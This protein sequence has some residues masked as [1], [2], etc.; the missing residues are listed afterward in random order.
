MYCILPN[1]SSSFS[2]V[3]MLG[4][5]SNSGNPVHAFNI[6]SI[7]ASTPPD[8]QILTTCNPTE[9]SKAFHCFSDL[10]TPEQRLIIM[11]S[12]SAGCSGTLVSGSTKSLISSFEYP[13]SIA[14]TVLP[15]N[16]RHLLSDQSWH[17][18][19]KKYT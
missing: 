18:A 17:I 9:S 8:L 16:S 6:V 5:C 2:K 10:S 13:F 12:N 19:R 4:T 11:M 15:K 14:F 7:M 3:K 1:K